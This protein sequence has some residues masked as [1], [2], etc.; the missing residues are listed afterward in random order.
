[1]AQ[2]APDQPERPHYQPFAQPEHPHGQPVALAPH[3]SE[4]WMPDPKV[5]DKLAR[6]GVRWTYRAGV[7][8]AHIDLAASRH[9][10]ARA[11]LNGALMRDKVED[12]ARA[13]KQGARFHALVA[14]MG[15]AGKLQ[16]NGGNHRAAGAQAAGRRTVD[17]YDLATD[18][19]ALLDLVT[20]TLNDLEGV[21]TRREERVQQALYWVAQNQSR[22]T[23]T[24]AAVLF[25]VSMKTLSFERIV[26][27]ARR[28]LAGVRNVKT[29]QWSKVALERIQSL[30]NDN[31][32]IAAARF[33]TRRLVGDDEMRGIV[34]EIK[35][36]HTE[37]AQLAVVHRHSERADLGLREAL[38]AAG[39]K[40][41]PRR[42][43]PGLLANLGRVQ[44]LLARHNTLQA[45]GLKKPGDVTRA[46]A[47]GWEIV[48]RMEEFREP[49]E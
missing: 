49:N 47:A 39:A 35:A 19:A 38:I 48:G 4:G 18:D 23:L 37:E 12:Y 33:Q 44:Q 10:N 22:V 8:I 9:N 7:P 5:E 24:D 41:K 14:H 36:E 17:L 27:Q 13:M 45:L 26:Q 16:L 6:L 43:A 32:R 1:M 15:P 42:E 2:H 29:D 40:P 20:L 31:V 30:D 28:A 34:A 21:G 46:K 25:N 3:P 11:Y